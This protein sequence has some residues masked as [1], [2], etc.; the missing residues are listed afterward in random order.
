MGKNRV[1]CPV[2]FN[3]ATLW[4]SATIAVVAC[5]SVTRW[6]CIETDK[7]INVFFSAL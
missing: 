7:D 3:R 1:G 4:V 5:L 6:Y 2:F